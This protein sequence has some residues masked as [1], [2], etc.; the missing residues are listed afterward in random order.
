MKINKFDRFLLL[1]T[2]AILCAYF[3]FRLFDQ[4]KI[5]SYFPL[6]PINDISSYMAQLF[7]LDVC[8]FHNFCPYW[9]NGFISFLHTAPGWFFFTY[10]LL[11]IFS[12]IELA[13]YLS[14]ILIYIL[15][16]VVIQYYGKWFNFSFLQRNLLFFF[17]FANAIA[18]GNHLRR[19]RPH[20]LLAWVGF[21]IVAFLVL[22]Y[23]DNKIDRRFYWSIL[24]L[25][26]TILSYV[27]IAIL[28]SVLFLS[29][30]YIKKELS[31][32]KK[33]LFSFVVVLIITSFFTIPFLLNLSQSS[34]IN[35]ESPLYTSLYLSFNNYT[36]YT[37]TALF[38][39]P[40]L[41]LFSL[42]YYKKFTK[43]NNSI[44]IFP[45]I[46]A[47]LIFTRLIVFIPLFNGVL[48]DIYLLFFV[49]FICFITFTVIEK[50][51]F[52]TILYVLILI[53]STIS[54]ITSYIHTPLFI[55]PTTA[56]HIALKNMLSE[57]DGNFQMAYLGAAQRNVSAGAVHSYAPI[58]Y[59]LTTPNG[60]YPHIATP[61]YINKT[62]EVDKSY[63]CNRFNE[64]IDELKI[65]YY[66]AVINNSKR[67]CDFVL[68]CKG[69]T[70][71]RKE[72]D[73]CLLKRI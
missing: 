22:Y 32:R 3:L 64:L 51:R 34:V 18:I 15:A 49:F 14:F 17:F 73:Y 40:I 61:L 69:W 5:I 68:T 58:Y 37:Q 56:N 53:I 31:D 6:D 41:F 16:W 19:G 25:A 24:G 72:A 50:I 28:S 48:E 42:F 7:F 33:I 43:N 35:N 30:L 57:I 44:F 8:G 55:E 65:K 71:K 70:L 4:A 66:I 27:P 47:F 11:K 26:I 20:E 67:K 59:N 62:V 2:F 60:W 36:K 21:F 39:V 52:R 23:K 45:I 12:D 38:L 1:T 54:V 29:L 10:P 13:T 46:L 9:Y 63:D